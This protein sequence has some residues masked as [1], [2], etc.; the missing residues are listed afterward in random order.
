MDKHVPNAE[1]R[2]VWLD[3]SLTSAEAGRAIGL[4]RSTLWKRAKALGLPPRPEGRRPVIPVALLAPLWKANVRV[5]DIA[6]HF[7]CPVGSVSQSARRYNLPQRPKGRH[8]LISLDAYRQ[9]LLGQHMA[10]QAQAEA[11]ARRAM[12]ARFAAE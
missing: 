5:S 6:A 11:A 9:Q 12:D 4:A 10:R 8:F 2:R 1:V 3:A 7:N